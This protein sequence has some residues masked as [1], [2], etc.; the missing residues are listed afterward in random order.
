VCLIVL[1][2][3][4]LWAPSSGARMK[5]LFY[6]FVIMIALFLNGR[7]IAWVSLAM[8]LFLMVIL[9]PVG[10]YKRRAMR[11]VWALGPVMAIYTVIGWGRPEKIFK[12]LRS[13]ST[14]STQE[15]GSTKARN[16]ENLGLIATSKYS[17]LLM[18]TGWGRPYVEVSNKYSIASFFKLWGYFPHNSVLGILGYTGILGFYGYWLAF[19]TA[20]FL[21]ARMARVGTSTIAKQ[22][23]IV[24]AVQLVVCANQFYGDMG[25]I[26]PKAVY[27]MTFSYAL[28]LRLPLLVGAWPGPASAAGPA[29]PARPAESQAA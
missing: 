9:L 8:G 2:M 18:G 10:K 29:G 15:D 22:T 4:A 23:G 5:N 3:R 12:P 17:G 27:M 19:P 7:R 1:M 24:G 14:V 16:M 20:M 21:N 11:A 25:I 13:L 26:Y 28:A 6:S